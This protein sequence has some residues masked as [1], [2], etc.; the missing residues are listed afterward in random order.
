MLNKRIIILVIILLL[1]IGVM[2]KE[3]TSVLYLDTMTVEEDDDWDEDC[4]RTSENA[5]KDDQEPDVENRAIMVAGFPSD[6]EWLVPQGRTINM[7]TFNWKFQGYGSDG[8]DGKIKVYSSNSGTDKG[9]CISCMSWHKA[10]DQCDI[11]SGKTLIYNGKPTPETWYSQDVTDKFKDAYN[12]DKFF[13]I[14]FSGEPY[15]D[16][17]VDGLIYG[18]AYSG[19][20]PYLEI[21][22]GNINYDYFIEEK[23]DYLAGGS[24]TTFINNANEWVM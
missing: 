20:E 6:Y 24:F 21:E 13:T 14:Y 5:W 4:G 23:D 10:F 7:V 1:A 15:S 11:H 19:N 12:S 9:N 16:D 22:F 17:E 18:M 8:D 3:G 2:K